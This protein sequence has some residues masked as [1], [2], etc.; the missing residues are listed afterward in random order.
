MGG[1]LLGT[2]RGA[3]RL[4]NLVN[5]VEQAVRPKRQ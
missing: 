1:S 3:I 2:N 4:I 5:D